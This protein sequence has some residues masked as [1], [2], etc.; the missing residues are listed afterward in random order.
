MPKKTTTTVTESLRQA[1]MDSGQT[2]TEVAEATGIDLGNLS[3]FVRGQRW[4]APE[5]IDRLAEY[6]GLVLVRPDKAS[7]RAKRGI[8]RLVLAAAIAASQADP[9]PAN[10]A[11]AALIAVGHRPSEAR[12]L[13]DQAVVTGKTDHDAGAILAAIYARQAQ[14][15]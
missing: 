6:L 14:R 4:L 1:V 13:V 5:N 9:T 2:L 8:S 12:A 7:G 3:R 10:D 15:A 11:Y